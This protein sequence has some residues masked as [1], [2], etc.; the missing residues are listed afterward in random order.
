[1]EGDVYQGS[2]GQTLSWFGQGG[3]GWGCALLNCTVVDNRARD[4]GGGICQGAAINSIVAFNL[5]TNGT[6][7]AAFSSLQNSCANDAVPS[8]VSADNLSL[9]AASP[10]VDGGAAEYPVPDTD[11]SGSPR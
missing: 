10:C 9:L 5:C 4:W 8:I 2:S 7:N 11:I 3:G 1:A 6:A